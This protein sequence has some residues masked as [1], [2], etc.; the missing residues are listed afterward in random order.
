[1]SED[2]H[3]TMTYP[4]ED[5]FTQWEAEADNYDMAMSEFVKSMV[6]AGRKNIQPLIEPDETNQELREQRNDLKTELEHARDRISRLEDQVYRGERAT[7]ERYVEDNPGAAFDEIVQHVI[8]TVPER[9]TRDLD[10]LEGE[11]LHTEDGRYYF[12]SDSGDH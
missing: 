5:Q 12:N 10:A 7:I 6:E 8:D 3:P 1:M 4:T 2:S 11:T 9:V